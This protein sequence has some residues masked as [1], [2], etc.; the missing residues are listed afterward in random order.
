MDAFAER[1]RA[2]L[3]AT[4]AHVLKRSG[5]APDVL[6]AQEA[7]IARLA[8]RGV[9]NAQIAEQLYISP[10]TVAYHLGKV[11]AKLS[12]NSRSQ[13]AGALPTE[14]ETAQSAMPHA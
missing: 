4:G 7:L 12:I 5:G 1:A 10:A 3:R 2:E 13:L 9:S 11:F 14:P 6:T 8:S